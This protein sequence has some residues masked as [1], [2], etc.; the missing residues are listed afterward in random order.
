[1]KRKFR[2]VTFLLVTLI[3][4]SGLI[5]FDSFA[6]IE[7][8]WEISSGNSQEKWTWNVIPYLESEDGEEPTLDVVIGNFN[9]NSSLGYYWYCNQL[10]EDVFKKL[11][12][13]QDAGYEINYRLSL[14]YIDVEGEDEFLDMMFFEEDYYAGKPTWIIN[15]DYEYIKFYHGQDDEMAENSNNYYESNDS[16]RNLKNQKNNS[17]NTKIKIVTP[18]LNLSFGGEGHEI[19]ARIKNLNFEFV[20]LDSVPPEVES[21]KYYDD[22]EDGSE[23]SIDDEGLSYSGDRNHIDMLVKFDEAINFTEDENKFIRTNMTLNDTKTGSFKYIGKSGDDTM[24]FRYN[25]SYGD[26]ARNERRTKNNGEVMDDE[27]RLELLGKTMFLQD[28]EE[29]SIS[30]KIGNAYDSANPAKHAYSDIKDYNVQIDGDPPEITEVRY[31]VF[32]GDESLNDSPYLNVGDYLIVK[33]KLG[34]L[35]NDEKIMVDSSGYLPLRVKKTKD[36]EIRTKAVL[37]DRISDG[38]SKNDWITYKYVVENNEKYNT[39]FLNHILDA[40]VKTK[41][42]FDQVTEMATMMGIHDDFQNYARMQYTGNGESADD[43]YNTMSFPAISVGSGNLNVIVDTVAPVLDLTFDSKDTFKRVHNI[44]MNPREEGSMLKS[45]SFY[46]FISKSSTAPNEGVLHDSIPGVKRVA[47]I[48]NDD[49]SYTDLGKYK[50]ILIDNDLYLGVSP[51]SEYDEKY[52]PVTRERSYD[53]TEH[54]A[55]TKTDVLTGRR[56]EISGDFYIHTYIRD[57]AGN[58]VKK[59]FGP[60]KLDNTPMAI[61]LSP[62]E[63]PKYVSDIDI[64]FELLK[65]DKSGYSNYQYMWVP[66]IAMKNINSNDIYNIGSDTYN[67][68]RDPSDKWKEGNPIDSYG[69]SK[70]SIPEYNYREHGANYLLIKAFDKAGNISYIVSEAFMFDKENPTLT[71]ESIGGDFKKALKNHGVKV[72]VDD[73]NSILEEYKYYFSKSNVTRGLDDPIWRTLPLDFPELPEDYDPFDDKDYSQFMKEEAILNTVDWDEEVL[74]GYTFLHVYAKDICGNQVS[75]VQSMILDNGGYPSVSFEYD[76]TVD[77]QY[78]EVIGHV[79]ATD[80]GGVE[81]LYYQWSDSKDTPDDYETF[82]L[83]G[84]NKTNFTID[85]P[86]LATIGQWYLHVKAVD[87]YGNITTACSEAYSISEGPILEQ[88]SIDLDE[89]IYTNKPEVAITLSKEISNDKEYNYVL[90][91]DENCTNEVDRGEFSSD[92]EII[93]IAL[94]EI[95]EDKQVFYIKIE[96]N[97]GLATEKAFKVEAIYDITAPTAKIVYTP[98]ESEGVAEETV[99]AELTNIK[100]NVSENVKSNKENYD[101]AQNGEFDFILTD[102]AGNK[103]VLTAIVNWMSE[104]RPKIRMIS[105]QVINEIYNDVE[106]SIKAQRPTSSGYKNISDAKLSYKVAKSESEEIERWTDYENGK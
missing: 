11:M 95:E 23:I 51:Y 38:Y 93:N 16:G 14:E 96:D 64:N 89:L 62:M 15:S 26:Y 86:S 85:T 72:I 13:Y 35:R 41:A 78:K 43:K 92:E 3:V 24:I 44:V 71:F 81:E 90:Y 79:L 6:E 98:E 82:D 84:K 7:S 80:D 8:D 99:R 30:D 19:M 74:N 68:L 83:S 42:Y 50:N 60:V 100:D 106:F 52:N 103:A 9:L 101:F 56:R 32:R 2:I 69:N 45:G 57:L 29:F 63:S 105:D 40:D 58:E 47:Y 87:V 54:I 66:P 70:I 48:R 4:F 75:Q 5:Q 1:M 73:E 46:Y 67:L 17:D 104:D 59:T 77:N 61:R 33:V 49:G 102:Q 53:V 37:V 28:L 10:D 97:I 36:E 65:E 91:D 34:N 55:G 39:L 31:D 18:N 12:E 27:Y 22:W 20:I 88:F 21:V 76:N 25:V 94:Q